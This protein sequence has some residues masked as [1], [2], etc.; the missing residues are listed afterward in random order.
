MMKKETSKKPPKPFRGAIDGVPFSIDNQPSPEAKKAGWEEFRKRRML[1][2]EM[3][4]LML[5]DDG[6]PTGTFTEFMTSLVANAKIGN[7]KAIDVISKCMEDD[8]TKVAAVN[9]S[10]EDVTHLSDTQFEKLLNAINAP[11]TNTGE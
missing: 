3:V 9:T 5:G 2:Q 10:G 1:T 11:S 6:Q 4:K 7:P 8:I